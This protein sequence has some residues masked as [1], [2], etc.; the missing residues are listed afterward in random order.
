MHHRL[1]G[2]PRARGR[3]TSKAGRLVAATGRR[4]RRLVNAAAG[5]AVAVLVW[6]WWFLPALPT[7]EW[8]AN[9]AAL[10]LVVV[11][12]AGR[13]LLGF[14]PAAAST[15]PET[16]AAPAMLGR[17]L[18]PATAV[19]AAAILAY[20]P[21]LKVGL[22]S[23]DFGLLWAAKSTGSIGQV[24]S[25]Q[26]LGFFLRPLSMLLWWL[27]VK[28][29]A[30]AP[31]G[32]HLAS[33]SL[34]AA[35][36]V[37]VYLLASR[38]TGSRLGAGLAG[39]LFAL[40]PLHVETVV[41]ASCSADLLCTCFCLLSLL[42][43]QAYL[44]SSARVWQRLAMAA[45][46]GSFLLALL[47]KEA[48]LALP[49]VALLWAALGQPEGRWRR[50]V[51]VGGCYSIVLCGYLAWRIH[52]RGGLGGYPL[53]VTAHDTVLPWTPFRHI[54]A[55]F[56]PV[57]QDL[58]RL[59]GGPWLPVTVV[60]MALGLLW[61]MR[62][63]GG[64]PG[65]RLMLWSGFFL[66]MLVPA[67]TLVAAA[68]DLEHSRFAYLPTIGL[69]WLFGDLCSARQMGWQREAG[70][71]VVLL[72]A[73]G[74]TSW[75]ILPWREAGRTAARIVTAGAD[76]ADQR[77]GPSGHLALYVQDLPET[78]L[79]AQVFRNSLEQAVALRRGRPVPVRV[80]RQDGD[81]SPREM[82]WSVLLPGDCLAA[83]QKKS[84]TFK[85]VRSGRARRA[86]G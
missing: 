11:A 52:V 36:S 78:H 48:A 58:F 12:V 20:L 1:E 19:I 8:S 63:L 50:T 77:Q 55:F 22:L 56:F 38:V 81:I 25:S 67:W 72:A 76:L 62:Q 83:W 15:T 29:W 73:A 85:V 84:G 71:A 9:V 17:R 26:A 5:I 4:D 75:Y 79:G 64:V 14:S 59:A 74:L 24:S 23:D 13:G 21:S 39:M 28:T 2:P 40:H 6:R 10:C 32:Y 18:A 51:M 37:L 31:M 30:G 3:R 27:G 54:V 47:S 86:A 16:R 70:I 46:L 42:S 35:N 53:H 41:W 80:V 7:A 43:L 57:H 68:P 34:H 45:A 61:M 66:F 60:L 33:V 49:A 82:A 69:V 65:R 44:T